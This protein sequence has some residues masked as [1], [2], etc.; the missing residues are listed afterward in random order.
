MQIR[1]DEQTGKDK[2]IGKLHMFTC[3]TLNLKQ[4]RPIDYAD[5]PDTHKQI[6]VGADP[7]PSLKRKQQHN[8]HL[9]AHTLSVKTLLS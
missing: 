7:C 5:P 4:N 1:T 6:T 2:V 3:R 9:A 8:K